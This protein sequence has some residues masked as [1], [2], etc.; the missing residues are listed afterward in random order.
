ML[1]QCKRHLSQLGSVGI[2]LTPRDSLDKRASMLHQAKGDRKRG[3]DP[4][5]LQPVGARRDTNQ[6]T[7]R[8]VKV[9]V[10]F[11]LLNCT[12]LTPNSGANL[13]SWRFMFFVSLQNPFGNRGT[14]LSCEFR[15]NFAGS[16]CWR[17]AAV[18]LCRIVLEPIQCVSCGCRRHVRE[19]QLLLLE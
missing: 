6:T 8:R 2:V 4:L 3:H 19:A 11:F 5:Y 12:S 7:K 18:E 9:H 16:V 17:L 10:I 13:S 1:Y 14:F 15:T